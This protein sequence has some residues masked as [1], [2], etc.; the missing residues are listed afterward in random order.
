VKITNVN[1]ED[2]EALALVEL[3]AMFAATDQVWDIW[4][5]WA[6]EFFTDDP[7][8]PNVATVKALTREDMQAAH[9]RLSEAVEGPLPR[10]G[11]HIVKREGNRF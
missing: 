8:T 4:R 11:L 9:R 1:V 2:R 7:G 3:A 6:A 10:P 5:L